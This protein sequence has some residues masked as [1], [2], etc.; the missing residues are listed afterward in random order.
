MLV[1]VSDSIAQQTISERLQTVF[2]WKLEVKG[3][4]RKKEQEKI[5]KK[6]K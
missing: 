4:K 5:Q 3:K 6:K 2:D 1:I